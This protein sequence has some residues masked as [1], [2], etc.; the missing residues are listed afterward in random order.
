MSVENGD[1]NGD[2]MQINMEYDMSN[3]F[4][5]IFSQTIKGIGARN[6]RLFFNVMRM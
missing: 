1:K 2:I 4:V 5:N 6:S 3:I